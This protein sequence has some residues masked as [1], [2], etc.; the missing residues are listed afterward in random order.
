MFRG[1]KAGDAPKGCD[2][3][4]HVIMFP[5]TP[6]RESDG[7]GESNDRA[8]SSYEFD[9]SHHTTLLK[10]TAIGIERSME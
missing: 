10:V 1:A 9:N 5:I 6:E 4:S 7:G 2:E 8:N 3:E